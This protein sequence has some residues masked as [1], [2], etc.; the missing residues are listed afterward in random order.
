MAWSATPSQ[1]DPAFNHV[2]IVRTLPSIALVQL[3]DVDS[4]NASETFRPLVSKCQ[5]EHR[6]RRIGEGSRDVH[7][8]QLSRR[9]PTR[10]THDQTELHSKQTSKWPRHREN[11]PM[12]LEY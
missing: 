9:G 1:V 3:R 8:D 2:L 11:G 4:T 12:F 7:G 10:Q 6:P 5:Q